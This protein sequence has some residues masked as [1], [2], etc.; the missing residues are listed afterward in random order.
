MTD[1]GGKSINATLGKGGSAALGPGKA[2]VT[3]VTAL[4]NLRAADPAALPSALGEAMA[5][6]GGGKL[7]RD[8]NGS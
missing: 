1:S 2:T 6:A 4:A 8:G 3:R 7:E 5:M